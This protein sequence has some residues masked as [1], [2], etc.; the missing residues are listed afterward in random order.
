MLCADAFE[1]F[2]ESGDVLDKGT[3]ARFR[4]YCLERPGDYD[5]LEMFTEFR[6]HRPDVSYL[7]KQRGFVASDN[8][9]KKR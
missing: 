9:T 1:A 4:K 6:G 5:A 7:L 3:A 2:R 8:K